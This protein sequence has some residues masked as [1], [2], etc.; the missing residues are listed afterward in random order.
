MTAPICLRLSPPHAQA[1][2]L[3]QLD[4]NLR[5]TQS[6]VHQEVLEGRQRARRTN[7]PERQPGA[8]L[9]TVALLRREVKVD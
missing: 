9:L 6:Q 7:V 5:P 4:V 1:A 8:N 2:L 3:E